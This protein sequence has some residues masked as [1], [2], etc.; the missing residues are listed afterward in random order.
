MAHSGWQV[1]S[2]SPDQVIVN[3]GGQ[4]QTGTYV[5]F[6]TGNGHDGSIFVPDN[7]FNAKNVRA[8]IDARATIID[9]VG[10]LASQV[11]GGGQ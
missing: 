8:M 3:T 2:M 4:T 11:A 10:A 6:R 9:E 5:F 7:H 1:T